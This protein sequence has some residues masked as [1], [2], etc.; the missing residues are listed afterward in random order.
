[1][2]TAYM[3]AI[4]VKKVII[5]GDAMIANNPRVSE[6]IAPISMRTLPSSLL[7]A[8]RYLIKYINPMT[9]QTAP[10]IMMTAVVNASGFVSNR[11]PT[12]ISNRIKRITGKCRLKVDFIWIPPALFLSH[13]FIII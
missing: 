4:K 2:I 3:I 8:R 6:K 7:R 12:A 11:T 5:N 1:M 13:V 10:K 9:T